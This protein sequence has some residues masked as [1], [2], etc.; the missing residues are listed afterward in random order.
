MP[1]GSRPETDRPAVSVVVPFH[2]DAAYAARCRDAL[3]ALELTAGDELIVA[4]NTEAR[5]ARN[6]LAGAATVVPA[7][8]ERSSYHARNAGAAEARTDWLLFIDADC[9]PAAG[10]AD[11][12]FDPPPADRCGAVGGGI[13]GLAEQGS[14]LARYARDRNFLHQS[15]GMHAKAGAAAAT[16]NMLVRRAAFD[17][18]GGFAEGIRSGGDVD[19][20]WRLQRAGWSLEFRPEALVEHRHRDTLPDFLT[21]IARYAAGSRW[22]NERHPGSAP[23]WPLVHGLVGSAWDIGGHLVHGRLEPAAFRAIDGLG[24]VAH[25]VGYRASNE[26]G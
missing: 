20:C 4:D 11:R 14:L 2:G 19:F 6:A 18:L 9:V 10:F 3:S 25:N 8:G 26:A 17:E 13:V 16:G 5:V 7:L 23:R 22:L 12:Y 24:L 21:T 1:T 15:E